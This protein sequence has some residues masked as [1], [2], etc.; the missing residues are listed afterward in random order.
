M[1]VWN[2]ILE[3]KQ[4][5]QQHYGCKVK[6]M[7][8]FAQ[9]TELHDHQRLIEVLPSSSRR[10]T[11]SRSALK[12]VMRIQDPHDFLGLRYY[13]A[14]WGDESTSMGDAGARL[15][16]SIQHGLAM[17]IAPQLA[18]DGT[19]GTYI[20]RG[21]RREALAAFKPRDEEAFT[22][23]NPR[24]LIGKLGQPGIHP[25]VLSGESHLREFLAYKLDWGGFAGVPLTLL[26]EAMHQAFYVDSRLPL[27]RYGTKVGSLQQWVRYDDLASDL[28]PS[29]F[30]IHEVHK[31]ALLDMRLLNT[32]RND[33][34]ILVRKA[35]KHARGGHEADSPPPGEGSNGEGACGAMRRGADVGQGSGG[36]GDG[37]HCV[38][39]EADGA[40]GVEGEGEGS[41]RSA[42]EG[43]H[44]ATRG[45]SAERGGAGG[46]CGADHGEERR[47]RPISQ[48][49]ALELIPID[50]GGC[51]PSQPEVVWY[52]WCWLSWPQLREPLAEP[53]LEYIRSLDV[54][55]EG[56]L[57]VDAGVP[58][59]AVR[60]N[61][62]ATLL[63]QRGVACGL[64]LYDVAMLLCRPD[65]D[66]PSELEKLWQQAERLVHM[67][68]ANH[69]LRGASV[70]PGPDRTL[71]AS[72]S[73]PRSSALLADPIAD[74]I[75]GFSTVTRAIDACAEESA[76]A[77]R[78][79]TAAPD[80]NRSPPMSPTLSRTGSLS[81]DLQTPT[82]SHIPSAPLSPQ[83]E[84]RVPRGLGIKRVMS[85]T[86]L[87]DFRS[88]S[89][90]MPTTPSTS[91][92][93]P[94]SSE[95]E[96]SFLSYYDRLLDELLKRTVAPQVATS[97]AL[98]ST[99]TTTAAAAAEAVAAALTPT[100]PPGSGSTSAGALTSTH[101]SASTAAGLATAGAVPST[102]TVQQPRSTAR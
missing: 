69:R 95:I 85:S 96:A 26:A 93:A 45:D 58:P 28:G 20:L 19:G 94:S 7:R 92:A 27:S 39:D 56:K 75:V 66:I 1:R 22:P 52:N 10:S 62:C 37:G 11:S 49:E 78:T 6:C 8:L 86:L 80:E 74:P 81:I 35:N 36:G 15:L 82:R 29:T 47:F 79:D 61:R 57:L 51:L 4:R 25:S 54:H 101:A 73:A 83:P 18:M 89:L 31:V 44:D 98:P 91:R 100:F 23:N 64:D 55:R 102:I 42:A 76:D 16:A 77:D 53:I 65:E 46:R 21:A 72:H 30:P 88:E 48:G 41:D 38:R 97:A 71:A 63:I 99:L 12:L 43:G 84:S 5:C 90:E 60:A 59:Q 13:V 50:H 33:A 24:G 87:Y 67:A 34:N 14:A 68:M 9:S 40:L 70:I 32:D 2:S 3:V 17:G